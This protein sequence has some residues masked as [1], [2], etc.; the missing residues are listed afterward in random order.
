MSRDRFSPRTAIAIV[1][2]NMIG[3]G[4]FT[5][6]GFQLED[7]RSGFVLMA[8]WGVG[9]IAAFCGALAYAELGAC[10]P[11]SGGEYNFLT[12]I[13]HPGAGFVSG[14]ISA[15]V[16]FAA[17]TALAAITFGSYLSSAV[18][19]LAATPLAVGLVATLTLLHA[20]THRNS[21]GVQNAF[22]VIK[23][24]L[25][26][27]FCGA[28][29]VLAPTPQPIDFLPVAGDG[30]LL[31]SGAFAVSLIY[32]SYAY[33]GWNAATYLSDELDAPQRNLPRVLGFGVAIVAV[34]YLLLNFVFLYVAPT[35]AM[36]GR[37][38]IGYVAATYAFGPIGAK[39]MGIV[40][41]LL[42]VS[43]V[44]A[45]II[46]GPRVL[47][48]IGQDVPALGL[49]ARTNRDDVPHIAVWMQ[50]LIAIAFIVTA[51][52]Q[53]ILILSGFLLALNTFAAV[54]GLFVLRWTRPA[55]ERPFRA[56]GYPFTPLLYL[57]LTGWTMWYVVADDPLATGAGMAVIAAGAL[58]YLV[59]RRLGRI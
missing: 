29:L 57:A 52:F 27:A 38:E 21:A 9:G 45:M 43:T 16:G 34:L 30:A 51:S 33:T 48:V 13:Y 54:F 8:L 22:T 4:V 3:T 31:T 40:L 18:P 36:V 12:E 15:T 5:S 24:G 14:W 2:A 20:T 58:F 44:S 19:G 23:I 49:L 59:A 56:W 25:I 11:R 7:I 10:L 39:L 47:Q 17:P 46:A 37:V 35:S 1:I 42:L 55:L 6:L 53:K 26:L 50:G 32:V 28:A 41:A